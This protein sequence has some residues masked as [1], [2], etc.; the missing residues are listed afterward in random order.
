LLG[1]RPIPVLYEGL[2]HQARIL[3]AFQDYAAQAPQ[4]VEGFVVRRAVGFA[5]GVFQG[6][7]PKYVHDS[8]RIT[9]TQ[10]WKYAVKEINQ[11]KNQ[12]NVWEIYR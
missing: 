11:L 12:R 6:F 5:F 3:A 4:L 2:Y 7:V 9:T 8:F 10:H 1:L